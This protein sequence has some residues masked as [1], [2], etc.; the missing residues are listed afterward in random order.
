MLHCNMTTAMNLQLGLEDLLAD[1]RHARR[2]GDLG[3]L[4]LISY[5]EV[6][7]W[8]RDAG[9][10][11]LAELSSGLISSSPHASR[12]TFLAHIDHVIFD[13]ERA[14]LKFAEASTRC[15]VEG[16]R[17]AVGLGTVSA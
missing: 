14:R 12:E 4:A 8:A 5:C 9:E 15:G 7:R 16:N 11:E 13:L 2:Q 3:R 1:L 10:P 17:P 6:R